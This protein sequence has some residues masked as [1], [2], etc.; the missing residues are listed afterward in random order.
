MT[1]VL[2]IGY[3]PDAVD[4][5]DP[6]LPPGLNAE[7]IAAGIELGLEQMRDRGWEAEFCS[8]KPDET[9]APTVARKLEAAAYDCIVIGG[10]VRLATKGLTAFEAIVNAVHEGAPGTPIAFNTRPDDSADAAAR[11]LPTG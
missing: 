1:R 3:A 6:A 9:A 7:T 10:G 11:W 4:F 8:V 2:L 5:S